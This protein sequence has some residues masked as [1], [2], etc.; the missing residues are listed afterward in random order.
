MRLPGPRYGRAHIAACIP[1]GSMERAS[2]ATKYWPGKNSQEG[3][4]PRITPPRNT[5]DIA[6]VIT[7]LCF[8]LS[9]RV[10][11]SCAIKTASTQAIGIKKNAADLSAISEPEFVNRKR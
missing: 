7:E 2:A 11:Q 9:Q 1:S 3:P 10:G 4:A 8:Q 5:M 6:Q